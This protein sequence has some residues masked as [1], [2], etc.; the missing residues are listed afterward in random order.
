LKVKLTDDILWSIKVWLWYV[1]TGEISGTKTQIFRQY[2][3]TIVYTLKVRVIELTVDNLNNRYDKTVAVMNKSITIKC[4]PH[5][6][7]DNYEFGHT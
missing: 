3:S 7:C 2:Y 5:L 4:D 1:Q 6:S